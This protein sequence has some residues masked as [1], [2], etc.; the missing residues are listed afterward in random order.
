MH[1][2][3]A[4]PTN[5]Y[6]MIKINVVRI[7]KKD[8]HHRLIVL[9]SSM[10]GQTLGNTPLRVVEGWNRLPDQVKTTAGKDEFKRLLRQKRPLVRRK[11]MDQ[12]EIQEQNSYLHDS[13][14]EISYSRSKVESHSISTD[15][16]PARLQ[17]TTMMLGRIR[18][19]PTCTSKNGPITAP[20]NK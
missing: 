13:R 19:P 16:S 9:Q 15:V 5:S 14:T 11:I 17:P 1:Y 3:Y 18:Y 2:Y 8:K 20:S 10:L 4:N 6:R 12:R 7:K